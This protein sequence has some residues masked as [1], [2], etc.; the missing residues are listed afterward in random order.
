MLKV[1]DSDRHMTKQQHAKILRMIEDYTREH[2][3]SAVK[4]KNALI[5][6]GIY[7]KTGRLSK[8]Y[9]GAVKTAK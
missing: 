3:T 9:G 5:R 8:K 4:A 2:T 7:T 1:A 6:E